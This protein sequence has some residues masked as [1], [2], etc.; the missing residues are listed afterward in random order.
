VFLV[1]ELPRNTMGKIEKAKLREAY[2]TTFA[3]PARVR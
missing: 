2:K 1:K 3:Q